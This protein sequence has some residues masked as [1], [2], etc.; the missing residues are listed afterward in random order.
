MARKTPE[1]AALTRQQ[2]IESAARVFC[3]DGIA[4]ASLE[5]IAREAGVTRGAVYWYFDGKQGLLQA[6][7]SEQAL[8]LER[9][10]PA[11]IAFEAGWELLGRRLTETLNDD[12]SRQLSKIMLH[13]SERIAADN[14]VAARL[15]QIRSSFID[16]LRLLL[17]NAVGRGELDARLDIDMVSSV[18]QSCISGLL[19]DCLPGTASNHEQICAM[20][21][22]LRH[23][24]RHPPEH[25]LTPASEGAGEAC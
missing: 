7:L 13:K 21:D 6:L 17:H 5:N 11:D 10:L 9:E 16:H 19:F 20:L 25:W 2:I 22:T 23:L 15:Q 12:M 8:P 4:G 3:R 24:L 14:L 1:Q 18:F